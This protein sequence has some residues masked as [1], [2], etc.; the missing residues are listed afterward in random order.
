L[1][2]KQADKADELAKGVIRGDPVSVD[3]GTLEA[4]KTAI[5]GYYSGVFNISA[6]AM[7][8]IAGALEAADKVLGVVGAAISG[9][10]STLEAHYGPDRR[11]WPASITIGVFNGVGTF[12]GGA[13]GGVLG[14]AALIVGAAILGVTVG[15]VLIGIGVF[16]G[17]VGGALKGSELGDRLGHW[18][19]DELGLPILLDLND[20]GITT[21]SRDNSNAFIDINGDGKKERVGW[22]TQNSFLLYDANGDGKYAPQDMFLDKLAKL[23]EN[24]PDG[25]TAKMSTAIDKIKTLA[26]QY[27]GLFDGLIAELQTAREQ[28]RQAYFAAHPLTDYDGLKTL[29][30]N[31]DGK[32]DAKDAA[33]GKLATWRDKDGDGKIDLDELVR[34]NEPALLGGLL[35]INLN[36][37]GKGFDDHGNH[38]NGTFTVET[39]DGKSHKGYDAG[40]AVV[41]GVEYVEGTLHVVTGTDQPASPW[42]DHDGKASDLHVVA[43]DPIVGQTVDGVLTP[44]SGGVSPPLHR[45]QGGLPGDRSLRPVVFLIPSRSQPAKP[46]CFGGQSFFLR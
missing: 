46:A 41:Q 40:L 28:Y 17:A 19:A 33:W 29:D 36:T 32:V 38:I 8:E 37:D 27:P 45:I 30:S 35:A 16:V 26:R 42:H 10:I 20:K 7:P 34:V 44:S 14:G 22:D 1:N 39:A 5:E 25:V 18:T 2:R 6:K 15:P 43:G 3:K 11:S 21:I 31:K 23:P 12:A 24:T 4:V 13:V 9:V